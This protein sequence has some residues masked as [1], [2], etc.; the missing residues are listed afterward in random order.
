MNLTRCSIRGAAV[1]GVLAATLTPA[2]AEEFKSGYTVSYLG[3]PLARSEFTSSFEG[4]RFKVKG[5]ISSSG[6]ARVFDST[7]GAMQVTGRIRGGRPIPDVYSL[8]YKTD[9]KKKRTV[10]RFEGDRVRETENVPPLKKKRKNWVRLA[11]EDLRSVTDP[12]TATL[13]AAGSLDA[14]CDRTIR[15]YDG[16]MRADLKLTREGPAEW[17]K[18]R[19]VSCKARFVPVA[20]YKKGKR[21]I[22]YLRDRSEIS[23]TF[24]A[25]GTTGFYAPVYASVGTQIGTITISA[26]APEA[27]N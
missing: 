6:F 23:I 5:R 27:T 22:E 14:V 20:G 16:E 15:L 11:P 13:V 18:R 1:A 17:H 26:D 19:A 4:S 25:L 10:I 8:S 24:A 2:G 12:I 21:A 9:S 7:E 3:M